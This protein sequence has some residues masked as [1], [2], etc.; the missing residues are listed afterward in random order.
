MRIT[1]VDARG[2]ER[3]Y[4]VPLREVDQDRERPLAFEVT[5]DFSQDT[6][7]FF[8]DEARREIVRRAA[9]G[10][11]YFFADMALDPVAAGFEWTYFW[12]SHPDGFKDGYSAS[13]TTGYRGFLLYAQGFHSDRQFSPDNRAAAV[14]SLRL[15][16]DRDDR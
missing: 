9:R 3:A 14:V 10:W 5:V 15:D 13:N 7:A 8:A 4:T 2:A 11:A 16:P 12:N 6:E 1:T